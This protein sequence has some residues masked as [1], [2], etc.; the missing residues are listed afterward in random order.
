M[1]PPVEDGAQSPSDV[2]TLQALIRSRDEVM[3]VVAHDLQNP[4][5]VITLAASTLLKRATDPAFRRPV[6]RILAAALR[7]DRLVH[8]LLDI[9]AIERGQLAI[10]PQP[11]DP[12]D[13]ILAAIDSQQSAAGQASILLAPDIAR[14]C[15][16]STPTRS[17]CSRCSRT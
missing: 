8:D 7:A 14:T 6:E 12:A 3:A 16:P 13:L 1:P 4:L 9:G 2:A 17:A 5:N 11:L 15:R 10:R